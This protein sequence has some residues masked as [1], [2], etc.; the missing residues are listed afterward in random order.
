MMA[1][2]LLNPA[3]LTILGIGCVIAVIA[4]FD[5]LFADIS[6]GSPVVRVVLLA[7]MVLAGWWAAGQS[8]LRLE[9][10]GARTP[11]LIGVAGALAIALW[12]VVLDC[13]V[14]RAVLVPP[15]VQFMHEPLAM[16]ASYFILRTFNENII[17]RLFLT[18]VAVLALTRLR[19]ATPLTVFV[20]IV[21]VQ[22]VNIA[23]NVFLQEHVTPMLFLYDVL[24]YIVPGVCWGWLY[25]RFGF[26][27]N[28]IAAVGCHVFLQP[29][30]SVL[31]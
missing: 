2:S 8:G 5:I 9:G 15:Y 11:A 26:V 4:P 13:F 25:Y 31:F 3:L 16:R 6:F 30:I 21:A 27:T 22:F 10:H 20:A 28:E 24:R 23:A 19:V 29:M 18:S 12:V 1:R 17:Y 14:F 7:A